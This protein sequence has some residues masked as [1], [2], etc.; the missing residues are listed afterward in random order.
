MADVF[1]RQDIESPTERF[2]LLALADHA[3]NDGEN[4]Y[5]AVATICKKTG[6]SERAVQ[7]AIKEL[8]ASGVLKTD[9]KG[10]RMTNRYSY[11]FSTPAPD[12][13]PQIT[14][15]T[16]AGRAPESSLTINTK[17]STESLRTMVYVLDSIT[18]VD[19]KIADN[20]GRLAKTAK[21]LIVAGY[22]AEV[23]G[24]A[25]SAGGAWSKNWRAKNGSRPTLKQ[26]QELIGE[27]ARR[28]KKDEHKYTG[29][30]FSEYVNH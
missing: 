14:A 23:V 28:T 2:V 20:Y 5:P 21:Q 1:D 19:A 16:P 29:G 11:V 8:V 4:I 17:I 26:V 6:Y 13:P 15:S 24:S 7:G 10:K 18:G 3:D 22:D 30:D 9:G 27:F 25:F 12:A